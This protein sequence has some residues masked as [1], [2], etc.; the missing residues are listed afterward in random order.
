MESSGSSKGCMAQFTSFIRSLRGA[1]IFA[2]IIACTIILICYA[3]SRSYAP[4]TGLAIFMLVY[5][6]VLFIIF[7]LELHLQLAFIHWGWTTFIRALIG[8]V[9]LIITAIIVLVSHPDGAAIVG[10]V[11][12]ILTGI[13]FGYDAYTILPSLRKSH[14]AAPSEPTEGI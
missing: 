11:A 7:M 2:E 8:A 3:S 14:T 1:L 4:Y 13:L 12:S 5:C 10:G 9:A 6:I